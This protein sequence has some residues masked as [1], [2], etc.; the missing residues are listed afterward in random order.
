MTTAI[1]DKVLGGAGTVIYAVGMLAANLVI[2]LVTWY[3]VH[4]YVR[5][6]RQRVAEPKPIARPDWVKA[7][8]S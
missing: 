8:K 7:T 4:T 3:I 6:E 2:I 1:M 5:L